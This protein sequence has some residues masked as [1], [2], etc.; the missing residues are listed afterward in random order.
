MLPSRS[1]RFKILVGFYQLAT[2]VDDVYEISLPNE[3]KSLME[4]L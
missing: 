4:S 2:K 1:R 3:V